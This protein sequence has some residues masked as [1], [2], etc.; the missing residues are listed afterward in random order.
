M[1]IMLQPPKDDVVFSWTQHSAIKMRF[2]GLSP[3]KV[4]SIVRHPQRVEEA[5]LEGAAAA[6]RR[7][8]TQKNPTENWVMYVPVK[9]GPKYKYKIVSAWRYPGTSKARGPVP[10]PDDILKELEK[11]LH[12]VA[13]DVN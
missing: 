10:I 1:K 8:G 5:I 2:Y 3:Q 13:A 7:A 12:N 11:L 9:A 6:M 4:K